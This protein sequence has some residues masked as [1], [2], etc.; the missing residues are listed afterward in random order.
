MSYK[1]LHEENSALVAGVELLGDKW[2]LFILAGCLANLC[3]FNELERILGV[4][5]N[6]LSARLEKL[7]KAGLIEKHLYQDKPRRYEYR[8]TE[9]GLATSPIVA[10]ITRFGETHLV[11]GTAP[12]SLTHARC[13]QKIEIGPYCPKCERNID[14]TEI[15][16]VLNPGAGKISTRFFNESY[17]PFHPLPEK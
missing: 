4:N 6:V 15:K 5:R 10:A 16:P 17:T 9:A 12:I 11:K 13:G 8:L 1:T 7:I 2:V 3:R 14:S